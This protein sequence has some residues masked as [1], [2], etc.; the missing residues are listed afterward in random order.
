MKSILI[1]FIIINNTI[2][3]CVQDCT[4]NDINYPENRLRKAIPV[5][6][7]VSSGKSYFLNSLLGLDDL[8]QTGEG[9]ISNFVCIIRHNP[10]L[11]N[12][13]FFHLNF[14][15]NDAHINE[16]NYTKEDIIEGEENIKN[17]IKEI[18][19][20]IKD[21]IQYGKL[22]YMLEIN[23]KAI[24]NEKLLQNYDFYDIPG[25][26]KVGDD[27]LK[28]FIKFFVYK[29]DFGIILINAETHHTMDTKNVIIKLSNAI[30]PRIIENY[31]IILNKI[32]RQANPEE[33]LE[34][35]K[36]ILGTELFDIFKLY[37]N[38][39]IPLDSRKLRHINLMKENFIEYFLY[40][41]E[42]Y[43]KEYV[44]PFKDMSKEE[45]NKEKRK[46]YEFY[47]LYQ[48]LEDFINEVYE[49]KLISLINEFDSKN[50]KLEKE[51]IFSILKEKKQYENPNL[52]YEIDEEDEGG[53]YN[54]IKALYIIF[55]KPELEK[56]K[57]NEI[58]NYFTR[59]LEK[60]EQQEEIKITKRF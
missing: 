21:K 4:S 32:D 13:I 10:K 33:A 29:I 12:P 5:I 58:E 53:S 37:S 56:P 2:I 50:Y 47:S 30:K 57:Y 46:N 18:N 17:K 20:S 7:A 52:D 24:K 39:L 44:T 54:I 11:N 43:I 1:L 34:K 41:L 27:H 15:S 19:E 48:Y 26:N 23:I 16:I 25:F 22:F 60:V 31:L 42:D 40:L 36:E 8:L 28:N 38:T 3:Q 45:L 35:T 55:K 59:T 9:G 6:G 49:G 14:I 51:N